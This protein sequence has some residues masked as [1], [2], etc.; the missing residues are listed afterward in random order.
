MIQG[1]KHTKK[2]RK[3]GGGVGVNVYGQPDRKISILFTTY[4]IYTEKNSLTTTQ[5]SM[6]VLWI[7]WVSGLYEEV[8]RLNQAEQKQ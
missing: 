2:L 1:K 4:Q 7:L 5:K 3:V 8:G 6:T